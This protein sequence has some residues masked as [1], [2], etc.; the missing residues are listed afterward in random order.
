MSGL[1]FG[2]LLE[3]VAARIPDA[4]AIVH[5]DDVL[6]WWTFDA[7][8]NR[9]ARHLLAAGLTT[10]S[11]V[12]FY[13]RN[14]PAYPLLLA[15]CFKA[16]LVHVNVNYRYVGAE[17]RYLIENSDAEAVVFD[18]EFENEAEQLRAECAGVRLWLRNGPYGSDPFA[19]ACAEGDA[20]ALG[21]E[22]SGD[23]LYFMYTGGTTGHPKG[24]MWPHAARIQIIGMAD[25][26][27]AEAHAD[28]V[29]ARAARPVTIPACPMMHS[30][31]FTT[32]ISTLVAGG[33]VVLLPSARFDAE[34]MLA[35]I[36]QHAVTSIALV[37]DA[38]GVPL[39]ETLRERGSEFDL[40]SVSS[41]TSAGAM[42]S[43]PCKHELLTYF[44]KATL[45][46][47]LGSSEG[48]RLA[49]A[50][51]RAGEA[52]ETAHFQL[53]AHARVFDAEL[54]EVVPGSGVPGRI[55][56]R[57]AIPLGYHKDP[58]RTAETFPI[59]DGERWSMPG[60]W[61][62]VEA[63]GSIRLLGRGSLCINTGGEKV[64][65]EEVEEALKTFPGVRDAA[66]FGVP[67]PRW[68]Q[69]VSAVLS[70]PEDVSQDALRAHL[71]GVLA[72][73]KHP[74][75]IRCVRASFRAANG[76]MDYSAAKALFEEGKEHE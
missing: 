65:P 72:R 15:A 54:R 74:K 55:A 14:G 42:W 33:T 37:G 70:A 34:A 25:A 46:D 52:G 40:S 43:A 49:S 10:G 1:N 59:I 7:Q 44:P 2:D 66:V 4:P 24:V 41:I 19:S 5:G 8:A 17:L 23:D 30:T 62:T 13:L 63:D 29:A 60:D 32:A 35:L 71:G 48:S 67:D 16:R 9:L 21:I 26:G 28:A 58:E 3:A 50:E 45:R 38:F 51:L 20:T 27:S 69:A 31:G 53:A 61:C 39:L 56:T 18:A 73:Y 11:R 47:S 57:G 12:A 22:R 6:D 76:K 68:G 64:W 36:E 75:T